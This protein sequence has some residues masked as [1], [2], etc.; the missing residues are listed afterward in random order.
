MVREAAVVGPVAACETSLLLAR[1]NRSICLNNSP[2]GL[3]SASEAW[4]LSRIPRTMRSAVSWKESE[5]GRL[6]KLPDCIIIN[7]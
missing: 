1:W 5:A 3:I 2:E 6:S 7:E 4:L